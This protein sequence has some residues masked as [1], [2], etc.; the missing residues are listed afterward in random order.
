M[1]QEQNPRRDAFDDIDLMQYVDGELDDVTAAALEAHLDAMDASSDDRLKVQVLDQMS[2]TVR[3]YLEL[4]AD[5]AEPRLDAMWEGISAQ[6]A[7]TRSEAVTPGRSRSD[8]PAERPGFLARIVGFFDGYRGHIFT[9][10]VAAGA[11]AAIILALRPAPA[12]ERIIV[13]RPVA[14]RPLPAQQ[15]NQQ[16][17]G[18]DS[19]DSAERQPDVASS[20]VKL[21]TDEPSA[22]EI[23]ELEVFGG[24]GT[25][26]VMPSEGEDDVSATVIFID[27]DEAEGPFL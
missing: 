13:K 6:I 2:D 5:A 17:P 26:F 15:P 12:P 11:A 8:S 14:V 19:A 20:E 4:Q 25:V 21:V 27:F 22:P 24:S 3:S 10:A 7:A 23:Q 16:S 9:G 1:A 18:G